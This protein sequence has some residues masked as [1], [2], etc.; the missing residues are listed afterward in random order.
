MG[1]FTK[2]SKEEEIQSLEKALAYK[3]RL[4]SITNQE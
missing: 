4:L 3:D 1:I 2:K